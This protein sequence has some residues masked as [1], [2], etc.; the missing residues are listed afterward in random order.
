MGLQ[1]ERDTCK[2]CERPIYRLSTWSSGDWAHVDTD[3]YYCGTKRGQHA[4]PKRGT[5]WLPATFIA[6]TQHD[7]MRR[8][9]M[10]CICR[11]TC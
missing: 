8:Y 3:L 6:P 11:I 7:L 2:N 5:S 10:N 9:A 1:I 4:E